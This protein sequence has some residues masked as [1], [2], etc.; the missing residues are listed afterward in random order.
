MATVISQP[1]NDAHIA[2]CGLFCSNCGKFK[3]GRCQGC[4]VQPGYA[5]C[6]TRKCVIEKGIHNCAACPQFA[7]PR[8]FRECGK[9]HNF[10][11]RIF[12]LLFGSDRP[13]ALTMLRDQGEGAYLAAK[14]ASGKM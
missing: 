7:A 6:A 1:P 10:I 11:A 14:R 12:A 13:G 5:Q 9:I 2:A 4:Q 3:K 8:D